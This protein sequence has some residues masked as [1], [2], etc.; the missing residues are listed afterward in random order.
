[1]AIDIQTIRDGKIARTYR[2]ENWLS[3]FRAK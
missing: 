3:A 2:I 1:M